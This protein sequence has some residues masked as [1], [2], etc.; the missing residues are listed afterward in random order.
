MGWH[1][2]NSRCLYSLDYVI[3]E[4]KVVQSSVLRWLVLVLLLLWLQCLL[5]RTFACT[6]TW[7][8]RRSESWGE[9]VLVVEANALSAAAAGA[10]CSCVAIALQVQPALFWKKSF[11]KFE[12]KV[13]RLVGVSCDDVVK[14]DAR[15]K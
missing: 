12:R 8:E 10:S 1:A 3:Q 6:E 7:R 11:S 14:G 4:G 13:P 15:C 9:R 5:D 2:K